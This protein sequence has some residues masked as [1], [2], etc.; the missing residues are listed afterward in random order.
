M[1]V[2]GAAPLHAVSDLSSDG[3]LGRPVAGTPVRLVGMDARSSF[4]DTLEAAR[5]GEEWAVALLWR[6]LNPRLLRFMRA[7]H[8]DDHEDVASDTWLRV[9]QGLDRFAG[10]EAQ[11]RAWF[12][13]IAYSTSVDAIRRAARRP[14][15]ATNDTVLAERA[16]S[17]DT[18]ADVLERIDTD[19][20]LALVA[21]LP[22]AQADVVLLRVVAGLDTD[23][24]G[25]IIGKR[26]GAVRVLQHRAL[27]KL[28]EIL[29]GAGATRDVTR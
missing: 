10:N 19:R 26:P 2:A 3:Y 1:V 20:A 7:R 22:S 25:R 21:Q 27:R 9:S 8:F 13:S 16:A 23:E 28:A 17:D 12:F 18:A 15:V 14:S 6:D 24:V 5:R 11:F 29:D 4:D